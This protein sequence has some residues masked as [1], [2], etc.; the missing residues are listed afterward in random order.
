M[1]K[2]AGIILIIVCTILTSFGQYFMKLGVDSVSSLSISTIIT[3]SLILGLI[4]YALGSL[5][6]IISL[7]FSDLS[8]IYPFAS[9]SF[10]WVAII[11]AYMLNE[12]MSV[13]NWTGIAVIVLGVM[14][15][16]VGGRNG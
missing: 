9:L 11:G 3:L 4:L 7:R 13:L 1:N 5:L 14:L 15:V 16:G 12:I 6:L 8:L 10:V 2:N